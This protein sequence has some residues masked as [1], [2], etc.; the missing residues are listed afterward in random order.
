M[1]EDFTARELGIMI[2]D[3]TSKI[4]EMKEE[5]IK[6]HES[7]DKNQKYTNGQVRSLQLWRAYLVGAWAVLT[8]ITPIAWFL[9]MRSI[10]EFNDK[11]DTKINQAIIEN[12]KRIFD[13]PEQLK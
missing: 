1:P 4:D 8:I 3:L 11:I 6:S 13:N 7:L 12:N 2:K 10:T 5:N 9:L